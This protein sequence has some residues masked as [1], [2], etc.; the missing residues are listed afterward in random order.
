MALG[1]APA[2]L[3]RLPGALRNVGVGCSAGICGFQILGSSLVGFSL[4]SLIGFFGFCGGFQN[5]REP[6]ACQVSRKAPRAAP[7]VFTA[8][9]LQH[10]PHTLLWNG[11]YGAL[12]YPAPQPKT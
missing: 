5:V 8:R 2:F 7:R 12:P 6:F 3:A 10:R 1:H 11:N 4:K 9:Y